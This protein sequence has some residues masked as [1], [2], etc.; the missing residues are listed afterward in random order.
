MPRL[1]DIVTRAHHSVDALGR[2]GW[3]LLAIAGLFGVMSLY[4]WSQGLVEPAV[5]IGLL[6]I[7]LFCVFLLL[8]VARGWLGPWLVGQFDDVL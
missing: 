3:L 2:V 5:N 4:G 6:A 8:V 7:A 1:P